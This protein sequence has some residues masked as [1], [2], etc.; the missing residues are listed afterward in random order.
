[1]SEAHKRGDRSVT[2]Y[3]SLRSTSSIFPGGFLHLNREPQETMQGLADDI[4]VA[5]PG[6]PERQGYPFQAWR[7]LSEG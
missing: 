3:R 1:M 5:I 2:R 7:M 6:L 4:E